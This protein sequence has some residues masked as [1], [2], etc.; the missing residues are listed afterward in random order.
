MMQWERRP[1]HAVVHRYCDWGEIMQLGDELA[2]G[3]E[4]VYFD[5][6]ELG[7]LLLAWLNHDAAV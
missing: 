3:T 2:P 4:F 6:V 5:V 1:H 7:S